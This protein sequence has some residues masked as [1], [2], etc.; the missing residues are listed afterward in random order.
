MTAHLEGDAAGL[1]AGADGHAVVVRADD[2]ADRLLLDLG[3]AGARLDGGAAT[4]LQ[5]LA[6]DIPQCPRYVRE[7]WNP[8]EV[9]V[10][11]LGRRVRLDE[12]VGSSAGDLLAN[13]QHRLGSFAAHLGGI[14]LRVD[15]ARGAVR[16]VHQRKVLRHEDI[17]SEPVQQ[18]AVQEPVH[19]SRAKL[20]WISLL[21]LVHGFGHEPHDLFLVPHGS[22]HHGRELVQRRVPLDKPQIPKGLQVE[23]VNGHELGDLLPTRDVGYQPDPLRKPDWHLGVNELCNSPRLQACQNVLQRGRMW[24]H[25]GKSGDLLMDFLLRRARRTSPARLPW[26]LKRRRQQQWRWWRRPQRRSGG[27]RPRRRG[28]RRGPGEPAGNANRRLW[29]GPRPRPC[30]ASSRRPSAGTGIPEGPFD[31]GP[32]RRPSGARRRRR[33]CRHE[34]SAR[35]ERRARRNG[36]DERPGRPHG[37]K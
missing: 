3:V 27:Q 24:L 4:V 28:R 1:V 14:A 2:D 8:V 31:E 30:R 5:K 35:A 17:A 19:E 32:P 33:R 37:A 26:Q 9:Q 29:G 6:H 23:V 18:E 22:L 16:E 11:S 34:R 13:I 12:N 21:K 25:L 36:V 20:L 10:D 15:D 7:A